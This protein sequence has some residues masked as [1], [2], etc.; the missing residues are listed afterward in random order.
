MVMQFGEGL[1]LV[2]AEFAPLTALN[3]TCQGL[4]YLD[5]DV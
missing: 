5:L 4:G 1:L 3:E 2:D